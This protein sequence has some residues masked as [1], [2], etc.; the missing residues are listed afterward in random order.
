MIGY[1][2][3][4]NAVSFI[5][6]DVH[7]FQAAALRSGLRLMAVGIKPHRS[8]K[9]LAHA[10]SAASHYT[11]HLY[12]GKKDIERARSDLAVWIESAIEKAEKEHQP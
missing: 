4:G 6:S 3:N 8:W 12:K 5:G 10:L 2:D 7:T 9:S 11:G 1:D